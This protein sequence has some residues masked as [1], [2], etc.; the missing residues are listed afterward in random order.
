[1]RDHEHNPLE[2]RDAAVNEPEAV[3]EPI[4]PALERPRAG[5]R[6]G[7]A[8]A[9]LPAARD[10][11]DRS[12]RV[13]ADIR[14]EGQTEGDGVELESFEAQDETRIK[15]PF[16]PTQIRIATREPSV[17]IVMER[18]RRGEIDLAPDFQR[19]GDIWPRGTQ[20]RLIES[21]LLRI[22]L[23]VFYIPA[24]LNDNRQDFAGR[25]YDQVPRQRTVNSVMAV[26]RRTLCLDLE[27]E[28]SPEG[29][30]CRLH[31]QRAHDG[32][33]RHLS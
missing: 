15:Q 16:D 17:D 12:P 11:R 9:D 1:M 7:T 19:S 13:T 27:A 14:E 8:T 32:A 3:R 18:I 20:S 5:S 22:P 33:G 4:A 30:H 23:P 6:D 21:I 2:R 28:S 10:A 31:A 26:P 25:G 24:D 29:G